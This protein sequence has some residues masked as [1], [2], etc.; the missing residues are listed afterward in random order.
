VTQNPVGY[1]T[2]VIV[3]I[4]TTL[5]T[6]D[7]LALLQNN[8]FV[9]SERLAFKDFS[10]AYAYVY[11]KDLPVLIT[12]DSILHAIHKT[13]DDLLKRLEMSVL[14]PQMI[15]FLTKVRQQ[16]RLE[17]RTNTNP[18]L[19]PLYADLDLRQKFFGK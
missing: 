1:G 18:A 7:E 10:N 9:V 11:W 15:A 8:G 17:S 6:T 12:T 4:V 14:A 3:G 13:Y 2:L 5:F 19:A 16:M